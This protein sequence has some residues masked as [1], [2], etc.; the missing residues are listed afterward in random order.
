MAVLETMAIAMGPV[1]D[2]GAE[3]PLWLFGRKCL[4]RRGRRI[5][6]LALPDLVSRGRVLHQD[7]S[8]VFFPSATAK[9][10]SGR[11]LQGCMTFIR[12]GFCL[13]VSTIKR[14]EGL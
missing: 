4:E 13:Q 11:L 10:D 9:G 2:F 8:Q 3:K 12:Q 1:P 5:A 6:Q 7:V 14:M